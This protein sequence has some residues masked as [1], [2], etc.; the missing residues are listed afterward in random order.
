[1]RSLLNVIFFRIFRTTLYSTIALTFCAWIIQSSRYVE[2]LNNNLSLAKFFKFTSFLSVDIIAFI[3]PISLA[4]SAAFVFHRLSESN[5]I[6]SV[7]SSGLAPQKILKPLILLGVLCTGYLYLSNAYISPLAWREFRNMEY[8]IKNNIDPPTSSGLIFAGNNFSVYAQQYLGDLFFGNIFIV[9]SRNPKKTC[10]LFAKLGS[11]NNN[12]LTLKDG[13]RIEINFQTHNN[14]SANF[15]TYVY[16]LKEI[17]QI[18]E[19]RKN[20]NE[21]FLNQ[22]LIEH[23]ND[24]AKTLEKKALF[25]QKILSPLLCLIFSLFASFLIVLAPYTRKPTYSRMAIL[26]SLIVI[27]EGIFLS[28]TNIA[29]TN[30]LF[31]SINY[32]FTI[33]LLLVSTLLVKE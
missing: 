7:Q 21:K 31:S 26:I 29:I 12:I 9:D 10:T 2:L 33:L 20:S 24:K 19:L 14:S 28:F 17:I 3:L 11:I 23:P 25:H 6:I 27:T 22:L 16:N 4:I 5:Q 18:H 15:E 8:N 13:E 30:P 1:M 32:I